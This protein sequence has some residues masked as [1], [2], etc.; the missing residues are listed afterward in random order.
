MLIN[1][2]IFPNI[3]PFKQDGVCL[4]TSLYVYCCLFN[5]KTHFPL[6]IKDERVAMVLVNA[7]ITD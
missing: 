7:L 4:Y 2:F 6:E 3:L 1:F 5:N